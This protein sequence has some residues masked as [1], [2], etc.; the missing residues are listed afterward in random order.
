MASNSAVPGSGSEVCPLVE[1]GFGDVEVLGDGMGVPQWLPF[2]TWLS[3]TRHFY[4]RIQ[5]FCEQI[6]SFGLLSKSLRCWSPFVKSTGTFVDMTSKTVSDVVARRVRDVRKS[7]GLNASDLAQR[8]LDLGVPHLTAA[9]I[10]NI[11]TGRRD[12][13]G[14][15]RRTVS[16]DELF[17]LAAALDVAPV[18]LLVP[19]NDEVPYQVHP[20]REENSYDVRD[21]V[22][23]LALLP[24]ADPRVFWSEVPAI[25]F[26]GIFP[27]T[28]PKGRAREDG[29]D[30]G[31]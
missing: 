1:G 6:R 25:E 19:L 23:G 28:R 20:G 8:C 13:D 29:D 15:R 26:E 9:T 14:R 12:D 27:A 5:R 21:W 11:E 16:V 31:R 30:A 4:P 17:A 7:Q 22:R 24:G 3:F 2:G 10:S 18:H